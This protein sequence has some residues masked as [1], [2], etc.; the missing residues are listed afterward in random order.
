MNKK[1]IT[2]RITAITLILITLLVFVLLGQRLF[3]NVMSHEYVRLKGFY[4]EDKDS[5]D[6]IL[7]GSSECFCDYS[8]AE[9]YRTSGIAN[10]S[11]SFNYNPV[12]LWKYELTEITSRQNPKLL[13]VELNGACYGEKDLYNY[14]PI[15]TFIDSIPLSRN[16]ID[17]ANNFSNVLGEDGWLSVY[18]PILKYHESP[19]DHDPRSIIDPFLRG[20]P[21]MRG[22]YS[23]AFRFSDTDQEI[24]PSSGDDTIYPLDPVAAKAFTEFLDECDKSNI[25]N[26][27]FVQ[28]PHLIVN[29]WG[30]NRMDRYNELGAMAQARG[31]EYL[32]LNDYLDESKLLSTEDYS[33]SDHLNAQGQKKFSDWFIHHLV[34]KYSLSASDLTAKQKSEWDASAEAIT[35]F[36]RYWDSYME[37]NPSHTEE[38][39]TETYS[40][41][42][43]IKSLN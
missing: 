6:V 36:Y 26:I 2:K 1:A 24:I 28:F 35:K 34:E 22:A 13:V 16:K 29:E 37:E 17:C 23:H 9:A 31:Y 33:N 20:Y 3:F 25:E 4:Q 39:I 32:D 42:Q 30:N 15:R 7:L 5:L 41:I 21:L 18:F 40:L 11:Y 38:A 27:L 43:I 14:G 8:P 19:F 10:Y 12:T